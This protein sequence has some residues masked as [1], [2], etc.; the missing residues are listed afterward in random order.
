MLEPSC[1]DAATT[2]SSSYS[3]KF[4]ST[5]SRSQPRRTDSASVKLARLPFFCVTGTSNTAAS[6][7]FG[8]TCL[9]PPV[10]GEYKRCMK[11]RMRNGTPCA[12]SQ[13]KYRQQP[14]GRQV[15][16]VAVCYQTGKACK[17][18]LDASGNSA[19]KM[20]SCCRKHGAQTRSAGDVSPPGQSCWRGNYA[21]ARSSKER[22]VY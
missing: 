19:R 22:L 3:G 7:P 14:S 2:I 8:K 16:Q 21:A 17:N 13:A 10:K 11:R 12:D 15:L 1:S 18:A 6:T 20:A 5:A 4:C 9:R